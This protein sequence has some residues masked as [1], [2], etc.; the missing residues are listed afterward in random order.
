MTRPVAVGFLRTDLSGPRQAWD[1]TT[2]RSM[3]KRHGYD[4]A[5]TLALPEAADTITPLSTAIQRTK[6]VALFVPSLE[7]LGGTIPRPLTRVEVIDV[8][9]GRTHAPYPTF[10]P[11]E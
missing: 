6:A 2:M 1:E 10:S 7:H 5:K 4:L 8:D 11:A 3:A 9:T